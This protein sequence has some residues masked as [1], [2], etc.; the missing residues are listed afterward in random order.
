MVRRQFGIELEGYG[1]TTEQIRV[2]VLSVEGTVFV[3]NSHTHNG[4]TYFDGITWQVMADGSVNGPNNFELVSPVMKQQKHKDL[5]W[6]VIDAM[7]AAGAQVNRSA[8]LHVTFGCDN[9]RFRRLGA[10][11][12]GRVFKRLLETYSYFKGRGID[13]ILAPSRRNG[14]YEGE[15]WAPDTYVNGSNL[16]RKSWDEAQWT[17]ASKGNYQFSKYECINLSKMIR[18]QCIEFRQHQGTFNSTKVLHWVRLLDALLSYTLNEEHAQKHCTDYHNG[19]VGMM[20]CVEVGVTTRR[21]FEARLQ[22]LA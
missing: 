11:K 21:F 15:Q 17:E 16:G 12:K 7:L 10:A 6:K 4:P 8:G 13:T 19:I 18:S 20:D 5:A 22:E 9:S 1:M 3:D 2:A 14:A